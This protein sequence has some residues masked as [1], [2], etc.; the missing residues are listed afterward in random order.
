M[1]NVKFSASLVRQEQ[2]VSRCC[3]NIFVYEYTYTYIHREREGVNIR[4][5]N[6]FC[7]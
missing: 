6:R 1:D 4:N 5:L 3:Y 2:D 7:F